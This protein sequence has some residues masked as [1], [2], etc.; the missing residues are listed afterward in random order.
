VGGEK[1]LPSFIRCANLT[2]TGGQLLADLRKTRIELGLRRVGGLDVFLTNLLLDEGA[3]DQ[4]VEGTRGSEDAQSAAAGVKNGDADFVIDVAGQDGLIVD[5]SYHAVDD[6]GGRCRKRLREGLNRCEAKNY[7]PKQ[8][9][10]RMGVGSWSPTLATE[11]SRKDGAPSRVS[12]AGYAI[13]PVYD[14]IAHQ[15]LCPRLKKKLK[16]LASPT[17]GGAVVLEKL[18]STGKMG[19]FRL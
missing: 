13:E 18:Y 2:D 4:L 11:K 1:Y 5:Y 12:E 16:W 7:A 6:Y 15:K 9:V 17:V 14:R 3:A 8:Q 19:G 10:N